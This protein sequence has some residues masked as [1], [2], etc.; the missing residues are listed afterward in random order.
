L[1][2]IYIWN[3]Q[4][5]GNKAV[6][7]IIAKKQIMSKTFNNTRYSQ[8]T[9]SSGFDSYQRAEDIESNRGLDDGEW[10]PVNK[11]KNKNKNNYGGSD[12]LKFEGKGKGKG[13]GKRQGKGQGKGFK[14]NVYT[15]PVKDS[16][17]VMIKNYTRENVE[18]QQIGNKQY[19]RE[20][21]NYSANSVNEITSGFIKQY[22][23][24]SLNVNEICEK[25]NGV[26]DG[27]KNIGFNGK[28]IEKLT[29]YH[30]HELLGLPEGLKL[31]SSKK[32]NEKDGFGNIHWVNWPAYN[33]LPIEGFERTPEDAKQM[34]RVLYNANYT[35]I[36]DNK[37]GESVIQSLKNAH[38]KRLITDEMYGV[39]LHE[40][41]YI[42]ENVA[43]VIVKHLGNRVTFSKTM[44][45][46]IFCW[47]F[48]LYPKVIIEYVA[49]MCLDDHVRAKVG[50]KMP[51]VKHKIDQ[52]VKLINDGPDFD[53]P[54]YEDFEEVINS[55]NSNE[56]IDIFYKELS[57][58]VVNNKEEGNRC[59]INFFGAVVGECKNL[60]VQTEYML[61]MIKREEHNRMITCMAHSENYDEK[62]ISEIIRLLPKIPSQTKYQMCVLLEEIFGRMSGSDE[63][64][65]N[66]FNKIM[67]GDTTQNI[68]KKDI[69]VVDNWE[70]EINEDEFDG[71]G[72]DISMQSKLSVILKI[73]N[74]NLGQE[75][76][77]DIMYSLEI[78]FKKN[79]HR[80][81]L[82]NVFISMMNI[83]WETSVNMENMHT[84]THEL[85]KG[86]VFSVDVFNEVVEKF[87][88]NS[89]VI[90]DYVE[91]QRGVENVTKMYFNCIN[92]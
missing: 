75:E 2:I 71:V 63:N 8:N 36:T 86:E 27:C 44:P 29:A 15:E 74:S 53:S 24:G 28:L 67:S 37:Y 56:Q 21:V 47:I 50:N 23:D 33:K 25:L 55:W 3:R 80:K 70:D 41:V 62:V 76:M 5:I 22:I 17:S 57:N 18:T 72:F 12:N 39:M 51:N 79:D 11:K 13:K 1:K 77:D 65:I 19:T 38:T 43:T 10:T 42:P 66:A 64:I 52:Y 14:K 34:I 48:S 31:F 54:N 20:R 85:L 89:E 82:E 73:K 35:P 91:I 45:K 83:Y 78:L 87:K 26:I 32:T 90:M 88:L 4:Y 59:D 84:I 40:Y 69:V 61:D 46:N 16:D 60:Q 7:T 58:F 68:E 9:T 92:V 81:L 30:F 49:L 6:A